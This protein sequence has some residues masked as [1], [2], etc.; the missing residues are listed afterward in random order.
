M[1]E[2]HHHA[3]TA[4][5]VGR[6]RKYLN[7]EH[8]PVNKDII[9]GIDTNDDYMYLSIY[10]Y[11]LLSSTKDEL[12]I[13]ADY[14]ENMQTHQNIML[15]NV[16]LLNNIYLGTVLTEEKKKAVILTF[17]YHNEC[18]IEIF[19]RNIYLNIKEC[20]Q[21]GKKLKDILYHR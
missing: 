16:K 1:I 15:E 20:C 6:N 19:M 10:G 12:L 18:E 2:E 9:L 21:I 7:M 3:N 5:Y 8:I 11:E 4:T 17:M 14:L 13:F